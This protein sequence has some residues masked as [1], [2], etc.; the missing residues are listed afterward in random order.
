MSLMGAVAAA[1]I[2]AAAGILLGLGL[3]ILG[4][5]LIWGPRVG[6][7]AWPARGA[8]WRDALAGATRLT[9]GLCA[10]LAGYHA[11]AWLCPTHWLEYRV[12]L[13]RWW[14]LAAGLGVALVGCWV[15]ERVGRGGGV[16]EV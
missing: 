9:L 16:T 15:S 10:L 8:A 4:A 11:A 1:E 13:S 6:L 14:L 12:P 3:V 5:W 2:R 7:G